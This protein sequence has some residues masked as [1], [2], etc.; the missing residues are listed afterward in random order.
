MPYQM[1][2]IL[3]FAPYA[4]FMLVIFAMLG[5]AAA[6]SFYVIRRNGSRPVNNKPL[7]TAVKSAYSKDK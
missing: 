1:M 4:L 6:Y 2:D 7:K 3:R 5:G